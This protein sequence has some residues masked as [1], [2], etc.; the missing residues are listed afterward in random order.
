MCEQ[1]DYWALLCAPEA[2]ASRMMPLEKYICYLYSLIAKCVMEENP[3]RFQSYYDALH[4]EEAKPMARYL[5]HFTPKFL[6]TSN[7]SLLINQLSAIES[8]RTGK[9][10]LRVIVPEIIP[11]DI[12]RVFSYLLGVQSGQ[13]LRNYIYKNY[14]ILATIVPKN[15]PTSILEYDPA[16]Y[17]EYICATFRE[18]A[19]YNQFSR[20]IGFTDEV[21]FQLFIRI[22]GLS[23]EPQDIS[24]ARSLLQPIKRFA[25][26]KEPKDRILQVFFVSKMNKVIDSKMIDY[27]VSYLRK[28][29]LSGSDTIHRS[30]SSPGERL[31]FDDEELLN[32]FQK[33]K[34]TDSIDFIRAL[35]FPKASAEI[36]F[37]NG[38]TRHF[39][40]EFFCKHQRA[41]LVEPNPD[42]VVLL[43]EEER[44]EN[45]NLVFA[46]FSLD[47]AQIY[48]DRFQDATF[49]Y[50]RL[51]SDP[52][53]YDLEI[54]KVSE[55]YR[56]ST[57]KFSTE[58][59]QS[60]SFECV[61]LFYRDIYREQLFDFMRRTA[62]DSSFYQNT[63]FVDL[64]V[65]NAVVEKSEGYR[66]VFRDHFSIAWI[67][68][69]PSVS[70]L[71]GQK[72]RML[73]SLAPYPHAFEKTNLYQMVNV[74]SD[75][76]IDY[77]TLG[78]VACV[79][80]EEYL[81]GEKTANQL[82]KMY[83][84]HS[85]PGKARTTRYVD[86]SKE[87]RIWYSLSN[88]RG[89]AYYYA[90]PMK[91]QRKNVFSRGSQLIKR[92]ISATSEEQAEKKLLENYVF[93]D[94]WQEVIS[95][96]I[97]S[98]FRSAPMSLKTYWFCRLPQLKEKANY[99]HE[100][101]KQMFASKDCSDLMS[102][103]TYSLT[104]YQ[105]LMSTVISEDAPLNQRT[106]IWAQLNII[107]NLAGKEGRFTPN[108]ISEYV[109][110]LREKD[111]GYR[112]AR[113]A[114]A[115]KTY[116]FSEERAMI[117]FLRERIQND[118]VY[119]GCAIS[120]FTGM[121][122]REICALQWKDFHKTTDSDVMQLYVY[123]T[124]RSN[125][126][127]SSFHSDEKNKYRRVPCISFLADIL[128]ERRNYVRKQLDS[129]GMYNGVKLDDLPIVSSSEEHLENMCD[130]ADLKKAKD[131]MESAAGIP[132]LSGS[133]IYDDDMEKDTDFN[134]Y[135]SDRFRA[136]LRY[137]LIQTCNMSLAELNY[138]LGISMPTTFSKHYCDY[139]NDFAQLMLCR[140]MERW[141][142]AG[143]KNRRKA[144]ARG[145]PSGGLIRIKN[146]EIGDRS[147]L[148]V[149][150]DVEPENAVPD[151]QELKIAFQVQKGADVYLYKE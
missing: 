120:F 75:D 58:L 69:F 113:D 56:G 74:K 95:K 35:Y 57:K 41:L 36:A 12:S 33:W 89:N 125:G 61:F 99:N 83:V 30:Q 4:S 86:F 19:Y 73:M 112:A 137:R 130:P 43:L 121:D 108:P 7:G 104:D 40:S 53:Q 1:Q 32:A 127:V 6:T 115:K 18:W 39:F 31:F 85:A 22:Y 143:A 9:E 64:F 100:V 106:A 38:V 136:N 76:G 27:P 87:I 59:L 150:M 94:Q 145:L 90:C 149:S 42:L 70:R 79:P 135:R 131:K 71:T 17:K 25:E 60:K 49:A 3:G 29:F 26:L 140:K 10:F 46:F 28:V 109:S 77:Y 146:A 134:D 24:L 23:F 142:A 128:T 111:K 151:E 63:H 148:H 129:N 144:Q 62:V 126:E 68:L 103:Q 80:Y 21:Y 105:Q 91:L 37:E 133:V 52:N 50:I 78:Q 67:D 139:S 118:G 55:Q 93:E 119:V 13:S 2:D 16:H 141:L 65:P 11:G 102:D 84:P 110:S 8:D 88:G 15:T 98:N 54:Q 114:L 48:A 92:A 101:A 47:L 20:I 124:I 123:K 66:D 138:I 14:M 147:I 5:R 107:L 45:N 122:N 44:L 116:S 81:R 117:A 82:W 72:K 97:L 96:D 51:D 132:I 34:E